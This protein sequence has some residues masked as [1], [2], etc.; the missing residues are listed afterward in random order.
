MVAQEGV[1]VVDVV[2]VVVVV[3]V[4]GVQP[5]GLNADWDVLGCRSSGPALCSRAGEDCAGSSWSLLA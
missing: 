5:F 3:V 2:V 4:A 1:V